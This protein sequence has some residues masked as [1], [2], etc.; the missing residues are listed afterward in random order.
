MSLSERTSAA[1]ATGLPVAE[2]GGWRMGD[3][4]TGPGM[5]GAVVC[6]AATR[7]AAIAAAGG[8]TVGLEIAA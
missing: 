3:P 2:L 1:L 8:A 6:L 4:I 7:G 5:M